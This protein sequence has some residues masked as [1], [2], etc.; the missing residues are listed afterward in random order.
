F[1]KNEILG[2]RRTANVLIPTDGVLKNGIGGNKDEII[3]RTLGL[4]SITIIHSDFYES[5]DYSE[6]TVNELAAKN[7]HMSRA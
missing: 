2:I 7:M 3:A 6:N 4:K 5:I 1:R